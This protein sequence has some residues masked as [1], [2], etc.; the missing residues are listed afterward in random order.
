MYDIYPSIITKYFRESRGFLIVVFLKNKVDQLVCCIKYILMSLVRE[1]FPRG[2]RS[3]LQSHIRGE[4]RR[5]RRRR[6]RRII[7]T[8][9]ILSEHQ[10]L[11]LVTF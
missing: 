11:L 6:I 3:I 9:L 10:L 5:G 8:F 4:K 1:C 2:A 7:K